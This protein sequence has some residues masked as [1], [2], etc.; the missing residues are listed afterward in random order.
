M[1]SMDDNVVVVAAAVGLESVW[2]EIETEGQSGGEG[3]IDRQGQEKFHYQS[4]FGQ[5]FCTIS[6]PP[7]KC[8]WRDL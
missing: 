7:Q 4:F 1:Q 2:T 3:E 8:P 5:S 6:F